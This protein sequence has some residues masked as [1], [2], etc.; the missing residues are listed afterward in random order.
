M[1]P[2]KT[3]KQFKSFKS[4]KTCKSLKPFQ[5]IS[6]LDGRVRDGLCGIV[7]FEEITNLSAAKP[8]KIRLRRVQNFAGLFVSKGTVS[9]CHHAVTLGDVFAG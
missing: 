6:L 9:Q 2:F 7:K 3:F 8:V 4:V 1:K 5:P